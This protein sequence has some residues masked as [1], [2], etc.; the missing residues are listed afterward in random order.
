MSMIRVGGQKWDVASVDGNV[1]TLAGG[2]TI[3][4]NA[5]TLAEVQSLLKPKPKTTRRRKAT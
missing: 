4:V 1:V 3:K 2:G 5:E